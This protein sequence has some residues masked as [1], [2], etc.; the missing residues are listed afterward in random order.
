MVIKKINMEDK[1]IIIHQARK[2]AELEVKLSKF[3]A[4]DVQLRELMG[5]RES[6]T[7]LVYLTLEE[8]EL[9]DLYRRATPDGKSQIMAAAERAAAESVQRKKL[10]QETVK[11][12]VVEKKVEPK[13]RKKI[14]ATAPAPDLSGLPA[15]FFSKK[16]TM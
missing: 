3:E 10:A 6:D 9:I 7:L 13:A 4:I 1:E 16:T 5:K 14:V 12:D 15:Q 11:A 2:I 8:A